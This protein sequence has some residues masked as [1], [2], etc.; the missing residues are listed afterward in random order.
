M[1]RRVVLVLAALA[2]LAASPGVALPADASVRL[3]T[4]NPGWQ[5]ERYYRSGSDWFALACTATACRLSPARLTVRSK[6]TLVFEATPAVPGR[7]LAW[8]RKDGGLEWLAPGPVATYGSL[9]AKRSEPGGEGTFE[10]TLDLPAGGQARLV[11]LL[12]SEDNMVVLQLR[13]AGKRQF[14]GELGSCTRRLSTNY[15]LWAGDLDR[16][17]KPDYLLDFSTGEGDVVLFLS[18]AAAGGELVGAGG[19]YNP[20]P[21]E[22][23]CEGGD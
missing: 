9:M 21:R 2:G 17:G 13:A 8:L 18:G 20:P 15:F 4:G 6:S 19:L 11:P 14:L 5:P 10:V 22:E 16:D 23:P 7:V 12:N 3:V 1:G